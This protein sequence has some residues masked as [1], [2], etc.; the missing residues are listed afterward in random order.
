MIRSS[1]CL[2]D[3]KI[4]LIGVFNT[5]TPAAVEQQ[6]SFGVGTWN[7]NG[8]FCISDYTK[9]CRKTKLAIKHCKKMSIFCVQEAHGNEALLNKHLRKLTLD[10]WVFSS[11]LRQ[12][13]GGVLVFVAKRIAPNRELVSSEILVPG[14]VMK[15]TIL[16]ALDYPSKQ[17]VIYNIHNFGLDRPQLR[18]ICSNVNVDI[19]ASKNDPL[20]YSVFVVGDF[21]FSNREKFAFSNPDAV[22]PVDSSGEASFTD[23]NVAARTLGCVLARLVEIDARLP[24]RYDTISDSGRKLDMIFCNLPSQYCTLVNWEICTAYCPKDLYKGGLSDHT[25]LLASLS[26]RAIGDKSAQPIPS[27]IFGNP[28]YLTYLEQMCWESKLHTLT[29]LDQ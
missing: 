7:A 21:N 13:L 12:G 2:S 18:L 22:S 6:D 24:T 23:K 10:Y 28:L 9:M 29:V 26:L 25:I 19:D 11:F 8:L 3:L 20:A 17:Q 15:V 5:L 4:K 16:N 27:E 1:Q 14:R